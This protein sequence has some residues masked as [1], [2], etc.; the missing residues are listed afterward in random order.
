[1]INGFEVGQHVDNTTANGWSWTDFAPHIIGDT[2]SSI[3]VQRSTGYYYGA[4]HHIRMDGRLLTQNDYR[5]QLDN[6]GPDIQY[7]EKDDALQTRNNWYQGSWSDQC[8]FGSGQNIGH[9][10]AVFDGRD[11]TW[12]YYNYLDIRFS[13]FPDLPA[14]SYRVRAWPSSGG[15]YMTIY[16]N[17]GTIR[18]DH[19]DNNAATHDDVYEIDIPG[20]LTR[21]YAYQ[22][23]YLFSIEIKDPVDGVWKR[24]VDHDVNGTPIDCLL[25]T[26]PSPRD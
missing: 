4:V 22:Y 26:S 20:A 5:I 10:R 17:S 8:T 14:N 1:M 3:R 11:D 23:G 7:L 24:M 19:T 9:A 21:I 15:G 16:T 25:Y 6:V 13:N 18:I 12:Y 2:V